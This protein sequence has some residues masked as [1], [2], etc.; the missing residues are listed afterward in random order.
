M[1]LDGLF[2]NKL[3]NELKVITGTKINKI[4]QLGNDEF[5]M[6]LKG[7]QNM[8]LLISTN[9]S[10]YRIHL[11]NK[12]YTTPKEPSSFVMFLRK[13]LEGGVIKDITQLS[14]D[15]IVVLTI[16]K[17]NELRDLEEK[18]LIIQLVG[19]ASNL[20]L[21]D[22]NY[23]IHDSHKHVINVENETIIIPKATYKIN[24]SKK[25]ILE[26][27]NDVS[28]LSKKELQENYYGISPL[29]A[30][31][32]E[33][34]SNKKEFIE[35]LKNSFYPCLFTHNKEDFYFYNILNLEHKH[36]ETISL[37]LD[38]F[39]Y[40]KA[41]ATIIKQ[42]TNNIDTTVRKLIERTNRKISNQILELK[43]ASNH[44]EYKIL[45]E[46]IT[47]NLYQLPTSASSINVLNYY[48]NENITINLDPLL[49]VKENSMKYFSK[50]QKMKKSIIHLENQI[51]LAKQEL[52]YL[53]LILMQ[54]SQASLNDI[55]EIR[56][57][58]VNNHY[59]N[60]SKKDKRKEK[61][62]PL[63]FIA[64]GSEILVGKNNVQNELITHKLAKYNELWFHVKDGPGS[65]VVLRKTENYTESDIRTCAMIAS[66]Y[67]LHK[68]S[69]SVEVVYTL[70]KNIKKIP[71]KKNCFVTFSNE[72][73]IFI[74]P[75]IDFINE[76]QIK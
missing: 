13:H 48:T 9:S 36:F 22:S 64:N 46:L 28:H 59:I 49:T 23:L 12:T 69:S 16:L 53:N 31:S 60:D 11:T 38:Y 54:I 67:S 25:N 18:K 56:Q 24:I 57:E 40:D 6:N 2:I 75:N 66:F 52:D 55:N 43:D 26:E 21:T 30:N 42:K 1:A 20:I 34:F 17:N 33:K 15:R 70:V 4:Y 3:I 8:K 32:F 61:I 72:K 5:L 51:Q 27:T 76:L 29:V 14:L 73:S 41:I 71:G 47:A 19:K 35:S 37:M 58:L 68:D 63:I 44:E 39:Y 62:L 45:G 50:Y 10:N 74:D 7:K 65:H